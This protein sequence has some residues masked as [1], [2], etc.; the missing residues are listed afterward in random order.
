MTEQDII[1]HFGGNTVYIFAGSLDEL[2]EFQVAQGSSYNTL[3]SG[4]VLYFW[5]EKPVS[6][7]KV[8]VFYN[9][10]A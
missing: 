9:G 7:E 2:H 6:G 10:A 5:S 1:N 4:G 8:T 3:M